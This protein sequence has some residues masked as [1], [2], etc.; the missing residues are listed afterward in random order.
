[1]SFRVLGRVVI[2]LGSTKATDDLL[3]MRGNVYS[4]RPVIPFFEM[5]AHEFRISFFGLKKRSRMDVQWSILLARYGEDWRFRRQIVE[6][7]FRPGSL[8][9][10][11]VIQERR[12][13]VLATRLLRSP[14]EWISH[15][16]LSVYF[17]PILFIL[18]SSFVHS[19]F[20]FSFQGEQL[21]AMTYG[22]EAKGHNDKTI[23]AAKKLSDIGTRASLP[24]SLLVNELPFRK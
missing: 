17:F 23:D 14:Q 7:S 12:A 11:R 5:Y 6:R 4:D 21:L 22:Y 20:F 2:I 15:S 16:E 9:A 8:S 3:G 19:F 1:M 10:Y 18:C 13:R 24:G